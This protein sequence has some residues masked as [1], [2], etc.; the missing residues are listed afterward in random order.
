MNRLRE[1]LSEYHLR[2]LLE[3]I[4]EYTVFYV[5]EVRRIFCEIGSIDRVVVICCMLSKYASAVARSPSL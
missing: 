1:C 2:A 5:D 3:A 4:A